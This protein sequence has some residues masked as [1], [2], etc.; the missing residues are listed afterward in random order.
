MKLIDD[1]LTEL[2]FIV[3]LGIVFLYFYN[4]NGGF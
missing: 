4:T 3:F 2:T 1:H